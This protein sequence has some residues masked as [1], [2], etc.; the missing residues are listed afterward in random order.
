MRCFQ[1]ISEL[2]VS[3]SKSSLVGVSCS[4]GVVRS[5]ASIMHCKLGKLPLTYLGLPIGARARSTTLWKPVIERAEGKLSNW[6]KRYLSLGGRITLI[7]AC[8]SNL[9]IYY[10]SLCRMPKFIEAKLDRIKRVFLWEG[11][12][13]KEKFTL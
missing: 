10:I 12:V 11:R 13:R 2:K 8:L 5:M 4:E 3:L 6:N 9:P 1:L 7:K